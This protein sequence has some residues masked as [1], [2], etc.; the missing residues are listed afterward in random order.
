MSDISLPL[1]LKITVFLKC[2]KIYSG[3]TWSKRRVCVCVF[4]LSQESW[5]EFRVM[6]VMDDLISESSNV[7]GVSSTGL[8]LYKETCAQVQTQMFGCHCH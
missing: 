7:V 4:S 3:G 5:Y 1:Y 6:A 8:F 2:F